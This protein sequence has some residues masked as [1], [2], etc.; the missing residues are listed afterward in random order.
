MTVDNDENNGITWRST[1]INGYWLSEML[2]LCCKYFMQE[3]QQF[4]RQRIFLYFCIKWIIYWWSCWVIAKIINLLELQQQFVLCN[5]ENSCNRSHTCIHINLLNPCWCITF[6]IAPVYS[7]SSC[8]GANPWHSWRA[9]IPKNFPGRGKVF[10]LQRLV[11]ADMKVALRGFYI[12]T[13]EMPGMEKALDYM[14]AD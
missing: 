10:F 4:T 12:D 1:Y 11:E 2:F 6:A 7:L 13:S 5:C 8:S 14:Q 9:R 3:A